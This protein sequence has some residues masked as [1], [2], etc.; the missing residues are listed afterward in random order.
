[1]KEKLVK[2][3]RIWWKVQ[4]KAYGLVNFS[5]LTQSPQ[6]DSR[7]LAQVAVVIVKTNDDDEQRLSQ[8]P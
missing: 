4:A 5:L 8:N 2:V 6:Y 7:P 1:M 3:T